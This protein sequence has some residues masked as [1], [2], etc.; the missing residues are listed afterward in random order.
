MSRNKK[1][2]KSEL[3]KDTKKRERAMQFVKEAEN[4]TNKISKKGERS[5]GVC[6]RVI[7]IERWRE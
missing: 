2:K 7:E 6:E 3:L 5:V 4:E 1:R